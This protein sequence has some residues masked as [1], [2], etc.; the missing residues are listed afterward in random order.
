[1]TNE[2]TSWSDFLQLQGASGETFNGKTLADEAGVTDWVTDLSDRVVVNVTGAD[3][4]DFLQAQFC[5]DVAALDPATG[6]AAQLN[7]YC[8]PKGRLLALFHLVAQ[9]ENGSEATGYRMIL[10]AGI[11]EAFVKRLRMFV[12]RA[13]VEFTVLDQGCHI[14]GIGGAQA[15]TALEGLFPAGHPSSEATDYS[16]EETRGMTVIKLPADRW[17]LVVDEDAAIDVWTALSAHLQCVGLNRWNLAGIGAGEPVLHAGNVEQIIPQMLNLQ[18]VDGLS[19]KKGCYPGQE[20]VARMQ[21]LGKLKRRMHRV[22]IDSAVLPDAGVK[23]TAGDDADAGVV[24]TAATG[25][26]NK[27][28]ALV[29][30]KDKVDIAQLSAEHVTGD[31]S[32][33]DLPYALETVE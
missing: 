2:T 33:L 16:V 30:I 8:N 4:G 10:P 32:S 15:F 18:A 14:L 6:H 12:L 28:H 7:G 3:A 1:M 31:F 24:V 21:Y 27:T 20:I 25:A 23:L 17:M 29:V 13:Q 26:D 5:N 11:A 9:S 22:A 19:F